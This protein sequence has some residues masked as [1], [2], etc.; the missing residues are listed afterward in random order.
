[1]SAQNVIANAVDNSA[2][3][4][5][6]PLPSANLILAADVEA[7]ECALKLALAE[8]DK[9]RRQISTLNAEREAYFKPTIVGDVTVNAHVDERLFAVRFRVQVSGLILTG[10]MDKSV[11]SETKWH[12]PAVLVARQAAQN[13]AGLIGEKIGPALVQAMKDASH[14]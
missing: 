3:D 10:Q 4:Q 1:M 12:E 8:C 5:R 11:F 6:R 2:F 14:E 7:A 9:L 13:L